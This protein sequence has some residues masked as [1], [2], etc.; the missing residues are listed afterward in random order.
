MNNSQ[1]DVSFCPTVSLN[2]ASSRMGS[3]TL[4]HTNLHS[5]TSPYHSQP[6]RSIFLLVY[7]NRSNYLITPYYRFPV[8]HKNSLLS[9]HLIGRKITSVLL[10]PNRFDRFPVCQS[11]L[12]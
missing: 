4:Y 2:T 11:L 8:C 1:L 10:D 3:H 12:N 7:H 5:N 6:F 9:V